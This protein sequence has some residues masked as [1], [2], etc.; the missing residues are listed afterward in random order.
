MHSTYVGGTIGNDS[1]SRW[2]KNKNNLRIGSKVKE[3]LQ[4]SKAHN[5]SRFAESVEFSCE[6]SD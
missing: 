5:K 2:V 4:Q 1:A 6:D 3:E